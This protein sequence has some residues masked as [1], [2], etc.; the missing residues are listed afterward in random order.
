MWCH[1]IVVITTA[2]LHS[3]KAELR[4]CM[5]PNPAWRF[6]MVSEIHNGE[7]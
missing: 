6:T 1:G 4:F 5:G 2:Q 3:T 7:D